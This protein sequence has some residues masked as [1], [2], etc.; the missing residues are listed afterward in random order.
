MDSRG[1]KPRFKKKGWKWPSGVEGWTAIFEV[2]SG[3]SDVLVLDF[4]LQREK[5]TQIV[6]VCALVYG[7]VRVSKMIISA[8]LK[9]SLNLGIEL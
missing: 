7:F 9:E 1:L 5:M 4:K 2:L 8:V 6:D 3:F